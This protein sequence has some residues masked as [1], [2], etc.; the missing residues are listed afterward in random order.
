MLSAIGEMKLEEGALRRELKVAVEA[1]KAAG[2]VLRNGFGR[3]HQIEYKGEADLVTEADKEAEQKIV[4]ILQQAFPDHRI[5]TEESGQ[6]ETQSNARW[7]IDPLDGTTNYVHGVPFFCTSVA[8]ERAGEVVVGV[9]HDPLASETYAAERGGGATL[10]GDPARVSGT[11]GLGQAL[12]GT[13][14][15]DRP[16]ELEAGLDLF[17][18]FAG[19]LRGVR[20]LGS[21]ALDLCYVAAG[22]LDGCY[23]QGFSAWDVASGV[24]IVEEAGGKITDHYGS[25]FDLE[26]SKGLVASNGLLH[27]DLISVTKDYYD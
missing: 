24:L 27:L 16:E 3:Q 18:R 22:R 21:G 1:A 10:N 26:E 19:S 7:I 2:E 15:A 23:E 6:M 14:F 4:G 8:L 11:E 17:R 13:S 25:E 5:L 20:R 12:L 9:V